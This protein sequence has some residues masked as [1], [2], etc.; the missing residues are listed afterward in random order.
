MLKINKDNMQKLFS[1]G[2]YVLVAGTIAGALLLTGCSR[3]VSTNANTS[4]DIIDTM[5]DEALEEGIVQI[6]DVPNQNF[7]LVVEYKCELGDDERWIV[8]SDKKLNMEI[9]TDGLPEGY[10]VYIDN[11]HT[12][13][14][15]CSK[16]PTVDG[17]TQDSMDDRVH[18]A[19]M[20]GFPI[21]DDVSYYGINQIQGQNDSFVSGSVM[22]FNG[23]SS[24][25]VS[26]KRF[27]ESDYLS[28]AVYANK[29]SSIIDLIIIDENGVMECVSVPSEVQVSIWPFVHKIK[30]NGEDYYLYYYF[31][32]ED[33]V[34]RNEE[35]SEDQYIVQTKAYS[36]KKSKNN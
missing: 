7:K 1:K 5:N 23:Y 2:K 33:G 3:E 20:I 11:V 13:T 16:Y 35:L 19:Q 34:V 12:D 18:N 31:D 4:Y 17:I 28:H 32:E 30:S 24:G 26:E 6:K 9:R 14:T 21:A 8:T 10:Q 22:G 27:V 29:I 25:S 15:I 36:Y